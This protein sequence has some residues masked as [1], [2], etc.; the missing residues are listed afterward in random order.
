M[1]VCLVIFTLFFHLMIIIFVKY[2]SYFNFFSMW[3]LYFWWLVCDI[4]LIYDLFLFFGWRWPYLIHVLLV[5]VLCLQIMDETQIDHVNV[6]NNELTW[7]VF[8]PVVSQ[9][10]EL[11]LEATKRPPLIAMGTNMPA[12]WGNAAST[13]S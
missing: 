11:R 3:W 2:F 9:F 6:K 7:F 4:I 10:R 1:L 12:P 8:V 13:P 5:F